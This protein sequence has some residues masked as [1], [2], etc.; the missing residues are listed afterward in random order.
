MENMSRP[1]LDESA[2]G[3]RVPATSTQM[4]RDLNSSLV[5]DLFW[6]APEGAG[7]TATELVERTGLTRS[8]V[9]A[10]ADELKEACW[11]L[12]D[13]APSLVPGRGRQARRFTF[14]KERRLVVAADIGFRSITS[15]VADLTGKLLG[16]ASRRFE[17]QE[18]TTDRTGEVLQT[19]DEALLAAGVS[20]DRV[21]SACFGLAAA[22]DRNGVPF[23]GNPYWDAVRIDFDRVSTFAPGWAITVE[24]DADLAAVA[25]MQGAGK[26]ATSSSVTLLAGEW[27][28]AGI[29]VNGELFRGANGG[30]GE[31]G[32]L[33]RVVGIG[34]SLGPSAV[35]R[36]L[37]LEGIAAGR[38]SRLQGDSRL[39]LDAIMAAAE[40]DD[41]LAA[42]VLGRLQEHLA[43]TIS[44][45]SSFLDPG[46]VI[47]AGGNA[48][49]LAQL[50][51]GVRVRLTELIPYPPDVVSS[52]LGR[53]VVLLGAVRSAI[54]V[55]RGA[56]LIS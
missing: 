7:L 8:T 38:P 54:A 24:N 49:L 1:V 33:E 51:S 6:K 45:L 48:E 11:L 28:G 55:V 42:E 47:I 32:Y 3:A 52:T 26:R 34:S 4:V 23:A 46:I 44:T 21:E 10:I 13:R 14:N 29:V 31:M 37:A 35:A 15:V 19:I 43:L 2:I 25:E 22:L 56:A 50:L 9:L 12:E 53:D 30:A 20:H 18:W 5:L 41:V 16:R 27:L 17:G 39:S 40:S 36:N